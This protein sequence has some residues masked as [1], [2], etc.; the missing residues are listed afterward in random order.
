MNGGNIYDHA[1]IGLGFTHTA[2]A[3]DP[4]QKVDTSSAP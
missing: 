3:A 4:G 2:L 1:G